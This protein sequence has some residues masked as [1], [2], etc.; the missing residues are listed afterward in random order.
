[1]F[2][3]K[4]LVIAAFLFYGILFTLFGQSSYQAAQKNKANGGQ[5]FTTQ[6]LF[7]SKNVSL[8]TAIK[9]QLYQVYQKLDPL[10]L[11]QIVI[12]IYAD[13]NQANIAEK[14]KQRLA[15]VSS[16]FIA[17]QINGSK[18]HTAIRPRLNFKS[19]SNFKTNMDWVEIM[20]VNE[21]LH[22]ESIF[23]LNKIQTEVFTINLDNDVVIYGSKGT[24]L[25]IKAHSLIKQNKA[26]A[27]GLANLYLN[28][29]ITKADFVWNNL[30]TQSLGKP[31]ESGG[32]VCVKIFQNNIA[33]QLKDYETIDI[34]FMGNNKNMQSFI[35]KQ[36]KNNIIW[37][38]DKNYVK[39]VL[40]SIN[41]NKEV[42]SL[43]NE[44]AN[45]SNNE[46]NNNSD[47]FIMEGNNMDYLYDVEYDNG[48]IQEYYLISATKLGFINCDRFL[49]SQQLVNFTIP[50]DTI[51]R[52][53]T[54]IIF[55]EI[56]SVMSGRIV[57][58]K[59]VIFENIPANT[60]ISVLSMSLINKQVYFGVQYDNSSNTTVKKMALHQSNLELLQNELAILSE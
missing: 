39:P 8:N 33:L 6:I 27:H 26:I 55:K 49:D 5:S 23:S 1:M 10:F 11:Q 37:M 46:Q 7:D 3:S 56:N 51:Y 14:C 45:V 31:L 38:P 58:S 48:G 44:S 29:Y 30:P 24:V 2:I 52:A 21:K 25:R 17:N 36:V 9:S 54:F 42:L 18:V 57:D 47:T 4:I 16:Y 19:K 60:E 41:Y 35:G 53:T 50:I 34:K 32:S 20:V 59:Y 22:Y 15:S 13:T 28:E 40:Q 12:A 43:L